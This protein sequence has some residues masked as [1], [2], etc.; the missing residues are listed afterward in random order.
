M[1]PYFLLQCKPA[2]RMMRINNVN[3]VQI[4]AIINTIRSA[5][6]NE[7]FGRLL[8]LVTLNPPK[9]HPSCV[10]MDDIKEYNEVE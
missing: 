1:Q 9:H 3:E 8:G 5:T 4:A 6:L 7:E 10:M 2:I